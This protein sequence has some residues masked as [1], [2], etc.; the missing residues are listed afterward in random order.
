MAR[1][2]AIQRFREGIAALDWYRLFFAFLVCG[3]V[4]WVFETTFVWRDTG[5]IT[6]R[7]YLMVLQPLETYFPAL[8]NYPAIGGVRPIL[9]L[10]FIEMYG[11]GGVLI[12]VTVGTMRNQPV[13]VF[14]YGFL[15]LTL[16]ELVTS[17][18]CD[19]FLGHSYWDY[20]SDFLN[21]QGRICLR[22]SIAWGLLSVVAT[23]VLQP[24]LDRLYHHQLG[25]RSFKT[26]VT[27]LILFAAFCAVLKYLVAP[28]LFPN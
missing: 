16:F 4:G 23:D 25:R 28:G 5:R 20:S 17:Y 19:F 9:G 27:V 10:P 21:F 11:F 15:V 6:G 18:F 24:F 13:R 22:S 26:V 7:G 14:L 8:M 12:L 3:F 1:T 2:E